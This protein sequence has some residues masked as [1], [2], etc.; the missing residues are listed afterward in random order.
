MGC[1]VLL[2]AC[3]WHLV[4]GQ[5]KEEEE[6]DRTEKSDLEMNHSNPA[7]FESWGICG[8]PETG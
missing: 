2:E 3:F 1:L 8:I 6:K 4:H 7:A 5:E